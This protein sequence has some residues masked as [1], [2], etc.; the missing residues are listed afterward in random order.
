MINFWYLQKTKRTKA[1]W[2][3]EKRKK[4]SERERKREHKR[5]KKYNSKRNYIYNFKFPSRFIK[6]KETDEINFNAR[7]YLDQYIQ[8]LI[9]TFNQYEKY[10]YFTLVPSK[11]LK[12]SMYFTLTAHLNID[13]LKWNTVLP[14]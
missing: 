12:C 14:K 3:K 2:K 6:K 11:S 7:F 9:S 13:R 5:E 4:G 8:T 10:K 1:N